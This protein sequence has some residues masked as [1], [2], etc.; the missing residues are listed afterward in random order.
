MPINLWG[1]SPLYENEVLKEGSIP[2]VT[3]IGEVRDEGNCGRAT[4]CG[5]E[6]CECVGKPTENRRRP[7]SRQSCEATNRNLIQGRYAL[8]SEPTF[9]ETVSFERIG[10]SRACAAKVNRLTQGELPPVSGSRPCAESRRRNAQAMRRR[11]QSAEVVLLIRHT[12][13]ATGR[14]EL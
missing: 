5:K 6:A 3:P 1:A 2:T 11:Q 14:T 10:K 13:L 12:P 4:D 7:H 8:V 9:S